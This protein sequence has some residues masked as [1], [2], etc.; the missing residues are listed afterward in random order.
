MAAAVPGESAGT[1]PRPTG[2]NGC[3]SIHPIF[4]TKICYCNPAEE[5]PRVVKNSRK[6]CIYSNKS[7]RE[8]FR[9]E[10]GSLDLYQAK[11]LRRMRFYPYHWD[12][13][14]EFHGCSH[15]VLLIHYQIDSRVH[16]VIHAE[17]PKKFTERCFIPNNYKCRKDEM[18]LFFCTSQKLNFQGSN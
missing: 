10:E 15:L 11:K 4:Y 5:S 8:K 17:A 13:L 9:V 16:E 6:K 7:T 14:G 1:K 12:Q 3:E 2:K 18:V